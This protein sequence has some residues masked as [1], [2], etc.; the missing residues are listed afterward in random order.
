MAETLSV[1]QRDAA[2]SQVI[3]STD[4]AYWGI[5]S[6]THKKHLAESLLALLE[7]LQK[8]VAAMKREGVATRSDELSVEVQL[9]QA[10]MSLTQVEDGLTL[11]KM[12]LAM[13]CG[14]PLGE[15][16]TLSDS[17]AVSQPDPAPITD[18]QRAVENRQEIQSL[19]LAVDMYREKENVTRSDY[20]P[21][22]ALTAAIC[23]P[24]PISTTV[25]PSHPKGCSTSG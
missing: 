18:V 15:D 12:N 13:I 1:H 19:T 9:N 24:R 10:R 23:S 8:D 2:A 4:Q 6:L 22:L 7:K 17:I 25:S 16:F 20:L 5:V 3:L 14:L 11:S 21:S